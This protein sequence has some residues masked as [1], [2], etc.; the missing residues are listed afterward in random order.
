MG[1]VSK[2]IPNLINGISQQPPSLRLPT[3]GEV[4]ENGLSDVVDGLKKRPPTKFVNKLL[5]TNANWSGSSWSSTNSDSANLTS[6]NT[7]VIN[8]SDY[9]V[10]TYKRSAEEQYLVAVSVNETATLTQ[11][12]TVNVSINTTEKSFTVTVGTDHSFGKGDFVDIAGFSGTSEALL[13]GTN[14]KIIDVSGREIKFYYTGTI[15]S[16][17]GS[18]VTL[19]GKAPKVLV[20]DI[21]GRLNYESN[22]ASW[23]YYADG[24]H[25]TSKL[26]NDK[27]GYLVTSSI[28]S[29]KATSVSDSTFLVNTEKVVEVSDSTVTREVGHH[30]L[31]YLKSVNYDRTYSLSMTPKSTDAQDAL[32]AAGSPLKKTFYC[33]SMTNT[34]DGNGDA[35]LAVSN[36][37]G[38]AASGAGA[39]NTPFRTQIKTHFNVPTAEATFPLRDEGYNRGETTYNGQHYYNKVAIITIPEDVYD[40]DPSKMA[41]YAGG[42]SVGYEGA[43]AG[44]VTGGKDDDWKTIQ[45]R[46][47]W[48]K[49]ADSTNSE[50]VLL[51]RRILL[52]LNIM[53]WKKDYTREQIGNRVYIIPIHRIICPAITIY[54][55]DDSGKRE[56]VVLPH[57]YT[58]EP[59]IIVASD[60]EGSYGDFDISVT[61]DDGGVNLSVFKESAKSFTSLPNQCEEG[62]RL[63]VSGD[64]QQEEDDFYVVYRGAAG[65]GAWKETH[66]DGIQ[67]EMAPETLPYT[68]KQKSVDLNGSPV[69]SFTFGIGSD[70]VGKT[71][72]D[73]LVGDENTNPFPSFVGKTISDIFF[74]RNRLGVLSGENVVFSEAGSYFNFFRTTVRTLLDADPIDVAVSQNEVSELKAALPIQDALLLFTELNQ[75]TITSSQLLTAAEVTI[76][77]STKFECDLTAA[78]VSAG[79]SAFFATKGGNYAGVREYYTEGDTEIKDATLVTSHVPEYLK[80]VMRKMVA[81]TNE[82]ML[83]CLTT[84]N[85]KE[86]YIYKWYNQG[87]QRVQSAWSKWIFDTDVVDISFNN[88]NLYI[89]YGDGRFETMAV[90]TDA[91]DISFGD[92]TTVPLGSRGYRFRS[93]TW[94]DETGST[95]V[96]RTGGGFYDLVDF[97]GANAVVSVSVSDKVH[98]SQHAV[99]FIVPESSNADVS[100][101][102]VNGTTFLSSDSNYS[103][104]P[105]GQTGYIEHVWILPY[106][107][108]STAF[109]EG[110]VDEV[111]VFSVNTTLGVKFTGK[112]H[113]VLLDHR[114]RVTHTL[115]TPAHTPAFLDIQYPDIDENTEF[116]NFRGELVAKGNSNAAKVAV[117]AHLINSTTNPYAATNKHTENGAEVSNYVD[118]GQPYTF[119][120][121]VSEQ[122]FEPTDGDNTTLARFQ[123]RN[124]TFNFNNTGTFDVSNETL[125]RVP[126]FSNFT[127][128]I[129]GQ[130]SNIIGYTAV[131]DTGNHTV[132][133]QSQASNAKITISN[134]THLPSTFQSAEWEGYVVLRNKRL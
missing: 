27:T 22:V 77:Q 49:I 72:A 50:G 58:D 130:V 21:Q 93:V 87:N 29:L 40:S 126:A 81:S 83:V 118:N 62:F 44:W 94:V 96:T 134:D 128:R 28:A 80:G 24:T 71:W 74:H 5:R 39:D 54:K 38:T 65:G 106:N 60:E 68:L 107:A 105:Y 63:K 115:S 61:D 102:T 23:H 47:G 11:D 132:N 75:F 73:R 95:D 129:L 98:S 125:G 86:A 109:F 119:K 12:S 121:G 56:V 70:N 69:L 14:K 113:D 8:P 131:V 34:S 51:T 103:T 46:R 19:T 67:H 110:L 64:N 79:N 32:T 127:G 111:A 37:I 18:T 120:Y 43:G 59:Y 26:N 42:A 117:C 76:D 133:I 108:T 25:T 4:Q 15:V 82:S 91:P 104:G 100:S 6:V 78:P 45:T 84:D 9:F 89:T 41:I 55:Y 123:L 90:R 16:A 17:S 52:P 101:F 114:K 92:S 20:Y 66:K 124:M 1:L 97:N 3:Q 112:Q 36:I 99:S 88:S 30:A 31:V 33:N 10:H 2:S 7:V 53:E 35:K 57:S 122:V 13:N 48:A 85:H 116:I